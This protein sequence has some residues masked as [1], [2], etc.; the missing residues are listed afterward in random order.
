MCEY[1]L[2]ICELK[3][4]SL[5]TYRWHEGGSVHYFRQLVVETSV[6][7][8]SLYHPTLDQNIWIIHGP[9]THIY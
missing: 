2:A 3:S 8:L 1:K 7:E 4:G 6:S 5:E 9:V